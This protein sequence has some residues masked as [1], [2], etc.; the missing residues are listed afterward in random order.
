MEA[1]SSKQQKKSDSQ[2][3]QT[4]PKF[5][6]L[7]QNAGAL[8]LENL[9]NTG[10]IVETVVDFSVSEKAFIVLVQEEHAGCLSAHDKSPRE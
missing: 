2:A 6:V 10:Y 9:L 8:E 3:A 1:D 7:H 4:K 5:R